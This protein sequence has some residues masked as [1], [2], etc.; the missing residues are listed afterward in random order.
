MTLSRTLTTLIA[1]LMMLLAACTQAP[2][3]QAPEEAV[4][5]EI[6]LEEVTLT[7]QALLSQTQTV[8]STGDVG[9]YTSIVLNSLGNPVISYYDDTRSPP[10]TG[11][12]AGNGDLKLVV[13]GNPT[14]SSGNTITTVDRGTT[15]TTDDVGKY[16][17]LVLDRRGFPVI[18]YFDR[19]NG[20][21]LA[22]CS[23]AT[24]TS[25]SIREVNGGVSNIIDTSLVLDGFGYPVIAVT[26]ETFNATGTRSTAFSLIRCGREDC[27]IVNSAKQID[28]GEYVSLALDRGD[29]P[30]I[31]YYDARG[32]DLKVANCDRDKDCTT[33][34]IR[35]VDSTGDVGQYSSLVLVP[36]RNA[37]GQITGQRPLISY[38]DVTNGD[39]KV[40]YCGD[41]FCSSNNAIHT[42]DSAGNVG[43]YTSLKWNPDSDPTI[44]YYDVTNQDLKVAICDPG[45]PLAQVPTTPCQE[46]QYNS[47]GTVD[48]TG[49]VGQD[50]ALAV[51][52]NGDLF[53]SYYDA[54][55]QDLKLAKAVDD[56]T[57]LSATINVAAGQASPTAN[58]PINFTAVFS[59]DVTGFTPEDVSL[60]G[61]AGATTATVSGGP[62]SYTITVSGMKTSGTVIAIFAAGVA[63]DASGNVNLAPTTITS[64][65]VTYDITPPTA[66]PAITDTLGNPVSATAAGWYNQHVLVTWNWTDEASGS[67]LD[68]P[69]CTPSTLFNHLGELTL[70]ATCNDLVGNQGSASQTIKLDLDGP[71]INITGVESGASYPSAPQVACQSSDWPSGIASEAVP[72]ITDNGGGSFTAT[73]TNTDNAG[74]TASASVTY[75]VVP[76]DT[77][78][79]SAAPSITD[80]SG[81]PISPSAAGWY[82]KQVQVNW[83]WSDDASGSGIDTANCTTSTS[84]SGQGDLTLSATCNDVAGNQGTSSVVVK[85]DTVAPTIGYAGA[86][87]ASP[88]AK[89]W[90][91]TNVSVSFTGTDATSGI[92]SC[93]NKTLGEGLAKTTTGVCTDNAGNRKTLL[94]PAFNIDKT[95][96]VVNL[97]MGG[98]MIANGTVPTYSLASG[99][100]IA[101][102]DTTDVLSGVA[103]LALISVVKVTTAGEI[104]ASNPPT[105]TGTYRARCSGALDNAA[106]SN[107]RTVAFRVS[108]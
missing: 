67:G 104:A 66:A 37:L 27:S 106:N 63:T 107:A 40:A 35:I 62:K 89:G 74:N 29:T 22:R 92:A 75:S 83:N 59:K 96:P 9:Q 99:V 94:S 34:S 14:C 32:G 5:E 103:A 43:Q 93:P 50:N 13:C 12:S 51:A 86:S 7:P 80:T 36:I 33:T 2:A 55:N 17:S 42:V 38:Y 61:T 90:Y 53:I 87:P 48:S 24:C 77:T 16:N 11:N 105:I 52:S 60:S 49:D 1:A 20:L 79:P 68:T 26:T 19:G 44:S 10:G 64:N 28:A 82:N 3:P 65:I 84:S 108:K 4:V 88:N 25:K 30:V 58:G 71:S 46:K 91:N 39:L 100:P 23:N 47:L 69:T 73:C 72:F 98:S 81:N 18:S 85:V 70:T 102:C 21:M 101:S 8:D 41:D 57:L 15:I 56:K 95:K 54:S 76:P 31:S 6:S 97:L 78:A 45:S